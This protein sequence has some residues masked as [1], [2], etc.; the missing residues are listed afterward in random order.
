ML[1]GKAH[2]ILS[3]KLEIDKKIPA[4]SK[5]QAGSGAAQKPGG[6]LP[7]NLR[8]CIEAENFYNPERL[9]LLKQP[10]KNHPVGKALYISIIG[11]KGG[12][13]LAGKIKLRQEALIPLPQPAAY[14]LIQ[15]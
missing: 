10:H 15:P 11:V 5:I 9:Y 8:Q 14:F 1:S 2:S 3:A 6:P 13:G 12:Q 7:D 4:G